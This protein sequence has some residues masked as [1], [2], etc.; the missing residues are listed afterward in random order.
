MT[1]G[2]KCVFDW[3]FRSVCHIY[4]FHISLF[5]IIKQY[6]CQIQ[7]LNFLVNEKCYDWIWH[8]HNIII[9][10]NLRRRNATFTCRRWQQKIVLNTILFTFFAPLKCC[11]Q[12][13]YFNKSWVIFETR[14]GKGTKTDSSVKLCTCFVRKYVVR[15]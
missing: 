7:T 15:E 3:I 2:K 8:I 4:Q 6:V 13:H 1:S 11:N 9:W 10:N 14:I 12:A 5:I